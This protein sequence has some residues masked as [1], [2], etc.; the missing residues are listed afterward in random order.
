M[1]KVALRGTH[2]RSE[3][4][5]PSARLDGRGHRR[6]A[7][8]GGGRTLDDKSLTWPSWRPSRADDEK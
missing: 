8:E 2:F 3:F 1:G 5:P 7:D 6:R 4:D